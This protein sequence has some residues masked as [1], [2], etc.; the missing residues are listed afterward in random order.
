MGK[1]QR[2]SIDSIDAL[3]RGGR[4]GL[5]RHEL[6]AWLGGRV[7]RVHRRPLANL[8]WR[9]GLPLSGLKLLNAVVRPP[10]KSRV[11]STIEERL[12][13]AACL[14]KVG[15]A[16]EGVELLRQVDPAQHPR[17]LL[18]QVFA[19]V[20]R[21][22]YRPTIP[23]LRQ[24]IQLAGDDSYQVVVAQVN[25][26]YAHLFLNEHGEGDR[27]IR[28]VEE[29]ANR[30][31]L[32][33]IRAKSLELKCQSYLF[34]RDFSQAK[35]TIETARSLIP[36]DSLDGFFIRK[37]EQALALRNNPDALNSIR[38]EAKDRSH[39]ETLR[40]CD[41]LDSIFG[42]NKEALWKVYFGTPYP[43]YRSQL[44][45][46][47]GLS[48]KDTPTRYCWTPQG[49]EAR[50][51][52][53]V[54]E[55][56]VGRLSLAQQPLLH[57]MLVTFCS[58]FYRPIRLAS[59]FYQ[60][61]P[62]E[63]FHPESSPARIYDLVVRFRRKLKGTPIQ[64][65]ENGGEYRLGFSGPIAIHVRSKMRAPA[66]LNLEQ[67]A[68]NFGKDPFSAGEVARILN[69]PLR[70]AQRFL[71]EQTQSGKVE[72]NGAGKGTRYRLPWAS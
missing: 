53:H 15:A 45:T 3:I 31:N 39:W 25:L 43:S 47:A 42:G 8:A 24:Y 7:D 56:S 33:L 11:E 67:I 26:I 58:D 64:L 44:L 30:E 51:Q 10:P 54:E 13:Y 14:I 66:E 50:V 59:L 60:L 23:L 22:S 2:S 63:F 49:E 27:L 36:E 41:R 6:S 32:Q 61:H 69:F 71:K 68:E 37:L 70:S 65:L 4:I 72:K 48:E 19:L 38:Q 57:R 16:E 21:W 46:V 12:E 17:S 1:V 29:Y 18:Y 62:E 52:A 40:D 28:E 9:V 20:S 34:Q 55:G 5:A 35:A